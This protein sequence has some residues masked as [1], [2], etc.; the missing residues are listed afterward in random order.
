MVTNLQNIKNVAYEIIKFLKTP[1]YSSENK[2]DTKDIKPAFAVAGNIEIKLKTNKK[3][4]NHF[5]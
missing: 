5:V 2:S 1:V 3:T 4:K